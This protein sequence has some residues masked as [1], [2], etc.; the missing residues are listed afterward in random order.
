MQPAQLTSVQLGL[1]A[2]AAQ[3]QLLNICAGAGPTTACSFLVVVC[4]ACVLL[5]A[6]LLQV[7]PA[8]L[9]TS[10]PLPVVR[11][12]LRA[13]AALAP[14]TTPAAA[15]VPVA[16]QQV[17][18]GRPDSPQRRQHAGSTSSSIK[19]RRALAAPSTPL[20]DLGCALPLQ[21]HHEHHRQQQQ[22]PLLGCSQL[23]VRTPAGVPVVQG[24]SLRVSAGQSL[25]IQGPSG[26]GKS[27]LVACL[28][29]L[30]PQHSGSV[31][32]GALGHAAAAAAVGWVMFVPQ[33]PLAAP[34]LTLRQQ[35]LYPAA[36]SMYPCSCC[37]GSSSGSGSSDTGLQSQQQGRRHKHK[38]HQGS[39]SGSSSWWL[40]WLSCGL[41]KQLQ[42]QVQGAPGSFGAPGGAAAASIKQQHQLQVSL[43]VL[44]PAH[45]LQHQQLT[46]LCPGCEHLL[47]VL[48]CV[49]LSYLLSTL[50]NGLHTRQDAWGDVL[51]PGELQRLSIA[52]V[53]LHMPPLIV[54]DEAT[55]ALPDA[56]AV[57]LY[58]QLQGAGITCVSV[59]HSRCL[60]GVHERVLALAGDGTGDWCIS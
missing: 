44:P 37:V 1:Q 24:L 41:H 32:L 57:A 14:D 20:Q 29:G 49:G 36:G 54:L 6:C 38:Q 7:Y 56:A 26:C 3:Q 27:T 50:P 31:S 58:K 8:T 52:R 10:A 47:W 28:A 2:G 19:A 40:N 15:D 23:S 11:E 21:P 18:Q 17:Q 48:D 46:A 25:L 22:Q 55:S 34:G 39:G 35:L 13:A 30:W 12:A 53:L 9:F 60:V 5:P 43:P 4:C 45:A 33:R 16:A 42:Q 59:G 51:S